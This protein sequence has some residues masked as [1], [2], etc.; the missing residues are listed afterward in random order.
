MIWENVLN[1]D[2]PNKATNSSSIDAINNCIVLARNNSKPNKH[3]NKLKPRKEWIN[4]AIMVSCKTKEKLYNTWKGES[5]NEQLKAKYI[6]YNKL[7]LILINTKLG[8]KV[9]KTNEIEYIIDESNNKIIIINAVDIAN[10]FN[11]LF[12]T[13]GPTL[14][15]NILQPNNPKQSNT[16]LYRNSNLLDQRTP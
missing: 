12:C 15:R 16:R 1:A 9:N 4:K 11:D 13:I 3:K 7:L 8:K 14:S 2:D 10:N 5:D 6:N